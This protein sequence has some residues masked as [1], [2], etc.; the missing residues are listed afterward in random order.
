MIDLKDLPLMEGVDRKIQLKDPSNESN[1]AGSIYLRL[2]FKP[3]MIT[4]KKTST[5]SLISATKTLTGVISVG[6]ESVVKS[7]TTFVGTGV[8][9]VGSG[10]GSVISGFG[11]ILKNNNNN[12]NKGSINSRDIKQVIT[13]S[14]QSETLP[15]GM[16]NTR[17]SSVSHFIESIGNSYS[18]HV[19]L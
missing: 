6:G 2:L 13:E 4:K 19:K 1:S 15:S 3:Q 5:G 9:L 12:N 17:T 8:N 11:G 18:F 14:S 16:D 7:G 10:A